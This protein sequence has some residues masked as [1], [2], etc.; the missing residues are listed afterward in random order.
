MCCNLFAD[1]RDSLPLVGGGCEE[2][3]L[4]EGPGLL[5]SREAEIL[6]GI[7]ED[8]MMPAFKMRVG[9]AVE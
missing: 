9:G 2:D 4:S 8:G 1:L 7:R 6:P 5:P 3:E